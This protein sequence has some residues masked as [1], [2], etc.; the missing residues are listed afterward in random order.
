MLGQRNA[1]KN[2][3]FLEYG[4]SWYFAF[5]IYWPLYLPKS[6]GGTII[7]TRPSSDGPTVRWRNAN[8]QSR[9]LSRWLAEWRAIR[10]KQRNVKGM[11]RITFFGTWVNSFQDAFAKKMKISMLKPR[12]FTLFRLYA[13]QSRDM[14]SPFWIINFWTNHKGVHP[15]K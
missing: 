2:I 9:A 11:L 7:P 14:V 8:L 12:T 6:K 10:R 4:R 1:K 3:D 15:C 13:R 5:E